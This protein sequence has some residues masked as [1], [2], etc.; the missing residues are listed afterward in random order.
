MTDKGLNI[1]T[2]A[3]AMLMIALL[4]SMASNVSGKWII[5]KMRRDEQKIQSRECRETIS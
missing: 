2:V 1:P 4:V 5:K 3:I